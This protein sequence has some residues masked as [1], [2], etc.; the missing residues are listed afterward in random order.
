MSAPTNGENE[1]DEN[2][3]ER[4]TVAAKVATDGKQ[5]QQRR[6]VPKRS[7][8]T[9]QDYTKYGW[10]L[11]LDSIYGYLTRS[12]T[13]R[14]SAGGRQLSAA[15]CHSR[16]F[17]LPN[18]IWWLLAKTWIT[19]HTRSRSSVACGIREHS[20]WAKALNCTQFEIHWRVVIDRRHKQGRSN[21]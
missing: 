12:T 18:K 1:D 10:N 2:E 21:D 6:S 9:S 5:G 11:K 19:F 7:D 13:N 20:P 8:D 4:A 3:K 16:R 14:V 17:C 15:D